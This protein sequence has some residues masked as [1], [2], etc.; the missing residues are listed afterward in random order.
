MT[1]VNIMSYFGILQDINIF[2]IR[3]PANQFREGLDNLNELAE[4]IKQ[5]G[6]LQP[7]LVRPM[8]HEYEVVAGNRRLAAAKLLKLRKIYCH[9]LE[10]S[11]KEAYE[12]GLVENVQ[13]K[14]LNPIEEAVAF[15][16]YVES[17][18][19]GGVSE[20]AKRIGRSQEFVTKRI[21]LLSLPSKIRDEII[22]QRITPTV[23]LELLPLDK[24]S[25]E[26]VGDFIIK[27]SLSKSEARC[28]V[29]ASKKGKN[30]GIDYMDMQDNVDDINIDNKHMTRYEKELYFLDKTLM[31]S[32]VLMKSTLVNF[33]DIVNSVSDDWIL[34]ELLMQYR[35]II[36]GDID[37]FLKLRKRLM[38]KM[39]RN[40]PDT[41]YDNNR[42]VYKSDDATESTSIHLWASFL[43]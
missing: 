18:G 41:D 28:I 4:S 20:L 36:H 22:R 3:H 2:K 5:H 7:I 37:T 13:H 29:R 23:A 17:N 16:K 9:V 25:I 26:K 34:K 31:R 14:T 15:N 12:L 8:E 6:L 10:L 42:L 24:E 21:Q 40:Y 38:K 32:I 27:N 39:P 35:L 43:S 1:A 11:D 19:W 33:D 30:L